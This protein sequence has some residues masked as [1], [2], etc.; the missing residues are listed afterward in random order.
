M[1]GGNK[2]RSTK[3]TTRKP[4]LF[5]AG[6]LLSDWSPISSTPKGRNPNGGNGNSKSALRSGNSDRAKGSGSTSESRKPRGNAFGYVYPTVDYQEGSLPNEGNNA[7]SNL[8]ESHPDVLVDSKETLIVTY[9][10][11]T[12]SVEP[13]KSEF[14]YDYSTSFS[15]D[16]S[17]HRGLGF[18]AEE[19]ATPSG[20]GSSLQMEMKE[21]D[22]FNSSSSEEE[23][24]ANVSYVREASTDLVDDLLAQSS[25]PE[26]NPG[27]LS[28]GGMKLYTQDI[29]EEEDDED[30]EELLDEEKSE[31]SGS[32]DSSESSESNSD[33]S[34]DTSD[35][36]SDIDEEVAL[37]YFKGIGGSDKVV[38]IKQF[39]EP[40]LDVSDDDDSTSGSCFDET[41]KK[42][43]GISLQ[44][45]SKEYGLKKPQS[46]K[47]FPA[48]ASR[49]RDTRYTSSSALDDL[50]L[51]K[52]PRTISAR[53]KKHVARFPQSWPSEAQKNKNF[54]NFPGEK[55]KHRKETIA[56]KRRERMI[57]RGVDLQQ[58]NLKLQQLVLDG[59]DMFSFQS[60]HS[61]DCS[62]V[63][64]IA[65][66]YCLR[67]DCQ[68][69]GKKRF[70]T[71]TRTVHTCM[72]SSID[73]IRLEKLIGAGDEDADLAVNDI[74]PVKGDKSRG[75]KA[76]K[77][78]SGFSP[79]EPLRSSQSKSLK[80][81]PN[82]RGSSEVSKNKKNGKTGSYAQNPVSFVSSGVMQSNTVEINT[83]VSKETNDTC[84]EKGKG[85]ESSTSYGAFELH[86]TGFGSKMMA[87]MGFTE[88]R[89][90]GKDGQGMAE[91]IEVIQRPKLLGLGAQAAE[92]SGN[93]SKNENRQFGK[94]ETSG[95]LS[96]KE[97]KQ[98][99]KNETPQRFASFEM[100]TKGFGSKMMAK[101]GFVEGMGLGKDSQG[102]VNP[103]VAVKFPK[104]R[105]LGAKG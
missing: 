48:E 28:I 84:N 52:D 17:S 3:P 22:Y 66:I 94:N 32:E 44:D 61:K 25:S 34:N 83:V 81:T 102:M 40:V 46:G 82:H 13:Q 38:D 51:V 95:N 27:F 1:A 70:V 89:G 103:L 49:P 29:L 85:V 78:S 67:S 8:D 39:V 93:L 47:K 43:S 16:D 45:A 2:K 11:Q 53:K 42:L 56:L 6:G 96:K 36:D 9:E 35:S 10:A 98:F 65:A 69:S 60:M 100:H 18:C 4:A 31:S 87:K 57:R 71:V 68:G 33:G 101:M 37:D 105:G 5:V 64:R 80:N 21:S 74:K 7:D 24:D 76:A 55:K 15:L 88:G 30:G 50:M 12:P 14:T 41:L 72:P 73:K 77:G 59:V 23:M 92:T 91:P 97:N 86:T 58:I 104:S 75:K 26:K 19:E 62:Q 20:I 99:G 63:R 79:L 54:R 90:L